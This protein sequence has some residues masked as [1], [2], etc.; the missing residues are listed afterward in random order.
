MSLYNNFNE[1]SQA[2]ELW[3]KI[4]I[5]FQNKNAA[6]QVSVFRKLVRLRYQD[7]ASMAEHMNAFQGLVYQATSLE[8]PLTDEVL[9]LF[10]LG[11]LLDSLILLPMLEWR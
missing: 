9:A 5:M 1:E 7:G 4:D 3:E 10:L 2:Y 11:S 8:V 6:N